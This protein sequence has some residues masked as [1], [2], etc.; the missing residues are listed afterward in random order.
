M[1]APWVCF[2]S[3]TALDIGQCLRGK[4]PVERAVASAV[5]VGWFTITISILGLLAP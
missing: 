3:W 4:K 1:W 5:D 2:V